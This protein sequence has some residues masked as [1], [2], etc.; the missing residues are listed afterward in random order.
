MGGGRGLC[1]ELRKW[2]RPCWLEGHNLVGSLSIHQSRAEVGRKMPGWAWK[3]QEPSEPHWLP[4]HT[5]LKTEAA[6]TSQ[7]PW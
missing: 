2:P 5:Q 1:Q 7:W 3:W 6:P 4:L